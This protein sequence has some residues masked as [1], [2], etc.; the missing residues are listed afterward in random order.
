MVSRENKK[1]LQ[2]TIRSTDFHNKHVEESVMWRQRERERNSSKS[3]YDRRSRRDRRS[4]SPQL[5]MDQY[6]GSRPQ[7]HHGRGMNDRGMN[8]VMRKARKEGGQYWQQKL[9][10]EEEKVPGRWGHSGYKKLYIDSSPSSSSRSPSP[11][12]LQKGTEE[13]R[14]SLTRS[15]SSSFSSASGSV[16]PPPGVRNPTKAKRQ[17]PPVPGL[18][19]QASTSSTTLVP[20]TESSKKPMTGYHHSK[21]R[22]RS[23]HRGGSSPRSR[24][25]HSPSS[26]CSTCSFLSSRSRSGSFSSF[27]SRT[28]S[29]ELPHTRGFP[30]VP[31]AP[32]TSIE[33]KVTKVA[34][35]D[36]VIESSIS[37]TVQRTE[38]TV[39][40]TTKLIKEKSVKKKQKRQKVIEERQL[41][42]PP[43]PFPQP[44]SAA[45]KFD[46]N[47]ASK[48]RKKK[49]PKVE[50]K[51]PPSDQKMKEP[52]PH[53]MTV[54]EAESLTSSD[55]DIEEVIV[56]KQTNIPLSERFGKL[57]QLSVE[58][59]RFGPGSNS[60]GMQLKVVRNVGNSEKEVYMEPDD[61][62]SRRSLSPLNEQ[63]TRESLE[64]RVAAIPGYRQGLPQDP[65]DYAAYADYIQRYRHEMSAEEYRQWQT[66]WRE[67]EQWLEEYQGANA[68]YERERDRE[69]REYRRAWRSDLRVNIRRNKRSMF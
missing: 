52:I 60:R 44:P 18:R 7:N 49:S 65:R 8:D 38:Q 61:S 46:G 26:Y 9:I 12:Q 56:P 36:K 29:P 58:R 62:G 67:Y 37:T 40:E 15:P 10:E 48:K 2:N 6:R 5:R 34:K 22:G 42:P 1:F 4:R 33:K 55:S 30:T 66:W 13:N 21:P 3:H 59:Q 28:P 25:S 57:A 32:S 63:L 41:P 35:N 51:L 53:K 19:P 64:R 45:S 16:S 17:E 54:P 14:R 24:H 20:L 50:V 39:R 69:W 27:S 43:P 47:S 31:N 11:Q 68:F 23:P